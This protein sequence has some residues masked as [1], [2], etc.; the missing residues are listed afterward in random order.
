MVTG[1]HFDTW[2]SPI[3][4]RST[5]ATAAPPVN[6][7]SGRM[8]RVRRRPLENQAAEALASA[9]TRPGSLPTEDV[10]GFF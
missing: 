4:E 8:G 3:A 10:R 5:V 9:P 1:C 2:T 6:A 7:A